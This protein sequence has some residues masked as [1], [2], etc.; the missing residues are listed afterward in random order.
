[1]IYRNKVRDIIDLRHRMNKTTTAVITH[2]LARTQQEIEFRLY[3]LR[4]TD[5][6]R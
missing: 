3:I 1:M 4:A 5:S 6:H 2:T